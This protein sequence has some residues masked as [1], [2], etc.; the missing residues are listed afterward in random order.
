MGFIPYTV[1]ELFITQNPCQ[2]QIYL[3]FHCTYWL[4][5]NRERAAT[6]QTIQDRKFSV[7]Q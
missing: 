6:F 1:Q 5:N 7:Y 3:L 2:N 4:A